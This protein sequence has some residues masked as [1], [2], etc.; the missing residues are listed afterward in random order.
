MEII[1]N[2]ENGEY[3]EWIDEDYLELN[4]TKTPPETKI[5]LFPILLFK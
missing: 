1:A 4:E 3:A 2:E 5:K